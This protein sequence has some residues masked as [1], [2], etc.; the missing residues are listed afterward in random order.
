MM[1]SKV[2]SPEEEGTN[3]NGAERDGAEGEGGA[4]EFDYRDRNRA[5]LCLTVA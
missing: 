2:T 4:A 5:S 3:A 1:S